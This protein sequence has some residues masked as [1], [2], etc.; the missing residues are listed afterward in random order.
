MQ[1]VAL[2]QAKL[3]DLCRRDSYVAVRSFSEIVH[4]AAIAVPTLAITVN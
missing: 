4:Y 2:E 1:N 3:E